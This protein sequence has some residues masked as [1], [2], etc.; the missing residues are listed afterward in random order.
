MRI[1]CVDN[2]DDTRRLLEALFKDSGLEAVAVRDTAAALL[3]IGRER[4]SLYLIDSQLPG[5]SG[6]GLCEEIRRRDPRTPIVIFSGH[7]YAS[8]VA[9]GLR[10]GADVYLIKPNVSE[11]VP[12]VRRL[13]E[14]GR[15]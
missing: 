13:L 15:P 5:E 6:L 4:F 10:A 8:D 14:E 12:A 11:V 2:D 9:A 7:G 1:L 3:L